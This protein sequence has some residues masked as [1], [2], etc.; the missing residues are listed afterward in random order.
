MMRPRHGFTLLELIVGIVVSSVIA[1]LVYGSMQVG[2]DARERLARRSA[3]EQSSRMFRVLLVDLLR[4]VRRPTRVED[5]VFVLRPGSGPA[6]QQNSRLSIVTSGNIPPLTPDSD[7]IVTLQATDSGVTMSATP[8]GARLPARVIARVPD[9]DGLEVRL[10]RSITDPE[11][12][13]R[14]LHPTTL[15]AVVSIAIHSDSGAPFPRLRMR[16]PAGGTP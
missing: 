2:L 4:N 6:G 13:D 16:L 9:A 14:W 10:R 8:V 5:S 11:V 12:S 3:E 1:L 15:P 7:W